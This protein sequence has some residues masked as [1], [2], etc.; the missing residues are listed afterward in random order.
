MRVGIIALLQESNT[1]IRQRTGLEHFHQDLLTQGEALRDRMQQAHHE[2]SGFFEGLETAELEAVPIFGARALPYGIVKAQTFKSLESMMMSQ[3]TQALPLDG[4]LVA[5]HG[6]T[7]SEDFP[8]VDGHCLQLLRD[9]VGEDIPI[10]CTL[11]L[12]ANLSE[13]MVAFS[14]ALIAYRTNPH[15]DQKERGLEAAALMASTLHG[16]I[17]PVQAAAFPP[18]SINI[19]RQLT[20]EMPCRAIY[21]IAHSM[22]KQPQV[23]SS[24]ILLGFPYADVAEVGSSTV[25]VTNN[26]RAL[27]QRLA[28][29]LA[30]EIWRRRDAFVGQLIGIEEALRMARSIEGPVCLLDM[31]DNVGGGSPGDSTFLA[32]VIHK[33]RLGK[34]FLCLF[35]P[36]SVQQAQ[37]AGPGRAI[38]LRVGGKTDSFHGNPIDS[39]FTVISLHEGQYEETEPRHGGLKAYDQGATA[40][41]RTDYGLVIMLTSR[42]AVPWSLRQLTYCGLD[43]AAFHIL[44]AKGVHAPVAAYQTVC[45]RLIRVNTPGVTTADF[46]SLNYENRRRPMFPWEQSVTWPNSKRK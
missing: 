25:V 21:E 2:V 30:Q 20:S 8:D 14:N 3:L 37:A 44:V 35:D 4:L 10:F 32:E 22:L 34:S 18:M 29:E 23:L 16:N 46:T 15:L 24:S 27:A 6:A 40:V 11:D 17:Y 9:R 19:E 26:D 1:F 33:H 7:V 31:G 39:I 38:R 42:R 13:K 43:P 12:H 28:E 36:E 45:Q 5:L 41:I